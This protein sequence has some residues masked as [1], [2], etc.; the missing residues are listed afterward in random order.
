M[1]KWLRTC[2]NAPNIHPAFEQINPLISRQKAGL[3]EG[4]RS[5]D[6]EAGIFLLAGRL[7]GRRTLHYREILR[8]PCWLQTYPP[9]DRKFN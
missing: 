6:Q 2:E 9:M 8:P 7:D 1:T 5:A 4:S 3:S